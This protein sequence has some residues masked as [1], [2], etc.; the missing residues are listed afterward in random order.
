MSVVVLL[1]QIYF[2]SLSILS[3]TPTIIIIQVTLCYVKISISYANNMKR[4]NRISMLYFL[5]NYN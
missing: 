4:V 2:K 3:F 1:L 5:F